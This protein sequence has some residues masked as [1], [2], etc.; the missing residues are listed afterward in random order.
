MYETYVY[1]TF[2]MP[3]IGTQPGLRRESVDAMR[4][5]FEQTLVSEKPTIARRSAEAVAGSAVGKIV[6]VVPR[7]AALR[8][9]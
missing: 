9:G 5:V 8:R 3:S 4:M 1:Q 6:K 2:F 7:D